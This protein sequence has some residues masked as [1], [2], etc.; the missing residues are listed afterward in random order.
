VHEVLDLALPDAGWVK[1]SPLS[2]ARN[3][4]GGAAVGGR[5]YVV[6]GRHRWDE[7]A[8]NQS[9]LSIFDPA[10]GTWTDGAS[11]PL[12]RSEIAAATFAAEARLVVIGGSVNPATPSSDAFVYDP[13]TAAW[14]SLP[15]LPVPL[16]GAVADI[17][18]GTV[19]VTTGSPTGTAPGSGTYAG[20][21]F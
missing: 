10:G 1:G 7:K 18:D 14:T 9:A 11:L 21:C 17:I 3:H 15:P 8:S 19:Y 12:A 6:G 13:A 16:K 20:C 2:K 5:I 4:L